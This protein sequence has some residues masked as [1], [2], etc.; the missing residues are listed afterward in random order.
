MIAA[1]AVQSPPQ[2]YSSAAN[3]LSQLLRVHQITRT[4]GAWFDLV[5]D[6]V[7]SL[8]SSLLNQDA[9]QAVH[10]LIY[11]GPLADE[12]LQQAL[13]TSQHSAPILERLLLR[14]G[15]LES[16]EIA[17]TSV[18]VSVL[19]RLAVAVRM[20]S[21]ASHDQ[22][23]GAMEVALG[24][25]GTRDGPDKGIAASDDAATARGLAALLRV[26]RQASTPVKQRLRESYITPL[27]GRPSSGTEEL[28][29]E[30]VSPCLHTSHDITADAARSYGFCGYW[31][32]T[33][34]CHAHMST[35]S[36][37]L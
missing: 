21:R 2:L 11:N 17:K 4:E 3:L 33:R 7:E 18:V 35:H 10:R 26:G 1:N 5:L 28:N 9:V 29:R 14:L 36:L 23:V 8:T 27:A 34:S 25:V 32:K 12:R 13:R 22:L 15:A 37:R 6:A 19:S 30:T 16:T 20:S 24:H 31:P